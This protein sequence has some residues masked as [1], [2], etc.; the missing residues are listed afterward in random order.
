MLTNPAT[1]APTLDAFL[2][3]LSTSAQLSS[4][5]CEPNRTST[6]T[7]SSE[8]NPRLNPPLA[9][10]SALGPT[11]QLRDAS[12]HHRI[13]A[14]FFSQW[15]RCEWHGERKRSVLE[16][17]SPLCRGIYIAAAGSPE[18]VQR[19]ISRFLKE[20]SGSTASRNRSDVVCR[21]AGATASSN[22]VKKGVSGCFSTAAW[23]PRIVSVEFQASGKGIQRRA[24]K[25]D[26]RSVG[27]PAP[28]APL[29]QMDRAS[30]Y[31]TEG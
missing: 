6:E 1:P 25:C 21:P 7:A 4:P 31:G 29:S 18:G 23:Q 22:R 10:S 5:R 3:T 24:Q 28:R 16:S 15:E 17:P 2:Q 11:V 9:A 8:P 14:R 30:V 20:V 26:Q 27:Y 19:A 13:H 12:W